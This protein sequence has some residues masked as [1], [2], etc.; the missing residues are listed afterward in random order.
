MG[1][2][3]APT[4]FSGVTETFPEGVSG[5]APSP[6]QPDGRTPD[7]H[8]PPVGRRRGRKRGSKVARPPYDPRADIVRAFDIRFATGLSAVTIWRLRKDGKFPAPIRLGA[9]SIGWRRADILEWLA[10]R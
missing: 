6:T 2:Q 9:N 10:T 1:V 7:E 4:D 3:P 8:A 5:E